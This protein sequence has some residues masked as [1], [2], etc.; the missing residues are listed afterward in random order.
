MRSD[1]KVNNL[2]KGILSVSID[3][4]RSEMEITGSGHDFFI[5][6]IMTDG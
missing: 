3:V 4:I 2:K 5:I 1:T 6:L